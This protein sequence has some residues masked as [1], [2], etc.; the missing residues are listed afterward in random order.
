MLRLPFAFISALAII[1]FSQSVLAADLPVK[2]PVL[3][4]VKDPL[5]WTGCY[6]GAN[7]GYGWQKSS[8]ANGLD[9]PP[10]FPPG[11]DGGSDTGNGPVGG[12]QVGCDY[13]TGPWV[14]GAQ[15]MFDAADVSGSHGWPN[16]ASETVGTRAR[17][18]ATFTGRVGYT[19]QPRTLV[20]VKGGLATL[21]NHYSDVCPDDVA[22]EGAYFGGISRTLTGWILGG[23]IGTY[24]HA[25]LVCVRRIYI[26]SVSA[27]ITRQCF[28]PMATPSPMT[29][30]TI[31]RR[32][33]SG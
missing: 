5:T 28:T 23:R 15:A 24:G 27:S 8:L 31:S 16:F 20:Y 22:C 29:T 7:A 26:S 33:L 12:V 3:R 14:F 9:S 4:A 19:V 1:A 18:F 13:Q 17:W 6:I 25:E 21:R 32:F 10:P 30:T 2:A 11:E